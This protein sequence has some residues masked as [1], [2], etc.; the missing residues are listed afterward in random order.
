M[1]RVPWRLALA[2]L[3]AC[4]VAMGSLHGAVAHEIRPAYLQVDEIAPGRYQILW[5]TPVLSGAPLPVELHLPDDVRDLIEPVVQVLPD[6]VVERRLVDAKSKGLA[7]QRIAFDGLQITLTD[8]FVRVNLLG[9][10]ST[11]TLVRPSENWVDIGVPEGWLSII[12]KYVAMGALHI[13]SG[14][15]HLLFVLGLVALAGSR[16][17]LIKTITAF[18]VAHSITL[19]LATLGVVHF[20]A[21]SLEVLIAL[22]IFFLGPEMVRRLRGGDSLALRGPWIVAFAFGLLHGFGFAGGLS[23]AGL[24]PIEI[25]PALLAFNVGVELGQLAFV[26]V[27]LLLLRLSELLEVYWPRWTRFA[28]AYVV[29]GLGAF[30]TISRITTVLAGSV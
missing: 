27:I 15:D 13:L 29:G 24:A 19:A 26:A 23:L 7:G 20:P 3:V 30:W 8:V 4:L 21:A 10:P 9:R 28:P 16:L 25:P 6:S 11:T 12:S 22:S 18:T 1:M 17:T 2:W 5:R 14:P